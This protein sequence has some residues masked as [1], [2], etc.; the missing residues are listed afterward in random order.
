METLILALIIAALAGATIWYYNRHSNGLD[1]NKDGRVDGADAAAAVKN[2]VAGAVEDA[3][4]LRDRALAQSAAAAQR[5]TRSSK[6]AEKKPA[7]RAKT[8]TRTRAAP[9]SK[10][11]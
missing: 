6:P 3:R 10:K 2:A 11:K 7:V 1:V 8:A 9:K 4:D 5:R